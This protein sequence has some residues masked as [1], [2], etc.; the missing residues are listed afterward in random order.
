M[1]T[2]QGMS[3]KTRIGIAFVAIIMIPVLLAGLTCFGLLHFKLKEIEQKYELKNATYGSLYDTPLMVSYM[4]DEYMAQIRSAYKENP[5]QLE[6]NGYLNQ[7]NAE[8]AAEDMFI[9]IRIDDQ[10]YYNGSTRISD[11]HLLEALP[12]EETI[13]QSADTILYMQNLG[14]SMLKQ[15][16][17]TTTDG[18]TAELFLIAQISKHLPVVRQWITEMI[19]IFFIAML[20]SVL[21][22]SR[23]VYTGILTPLRALKKGA[24]NIR[25][26][27]LDF[28]LL[29]GSGISEIDELTEDFD[30][31][32]VRLKN[33][34]EEKLDSDKESK[35]L[36]SNISHDLKTPLTTIRGYAAGI[37]DGVA[38]TD[39]KVKHYV[40]TI[41][42]K[43]NDMNALIDELTLYSKIDTNRIPYSFAKLH[44]AEYFE[45]CVSE[46]TMELKEKNIDLIF[47]N[48]L[49]E[50]AV[51]IADA[52]QMKR[53]V[54]NIISNSAKY[55]DKTHGIINLRLRDVG[56]FVQ[57][58]I[59]DNGRGIP[60]KEV[61]RIFD[62]FYRTDT[63]RNNKIGGSGIGL[64]I[65]QKILADHEGRVWATSKEGVG[66][67]VYFVLRK[68]T[69][70][71]EN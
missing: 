47:F 67:T 9:A 30:E 2:K 62:R 53:V 18:R 48:Y 70:P 26:G 71:E 16:R 38:N 52:E 25:D 42:N 23:W 20:F 6:D 3:L 68:Y 50:D 39:E 51:V 44:V 35:E 61:S 12:E 33:S 65:V 45:D 55:M 36:I 54:V 37:I 28:Q 64:S 22:M 31:M 11:S 69:D 46:M 8:R 27:N 32:R 41:Y 58:E 29:P 49:Q 7:M 24:R 21:L 15:M 19:L 1:K 63:S 57:V 59:E 34:A 14:Q 4:M 17:F 56:D 5:K 43:A 13:S 66:T 40:Q 10:I 60:Q